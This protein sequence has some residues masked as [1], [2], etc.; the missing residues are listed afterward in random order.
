MPRTVSDRTVHSNKIEE[1]TRLWTTTTRTWQRIS[2]SKKLSSSL[3]LFAWSACVFSNGASAWIEPAGLKTPFAVPATNIE[4]LA[5]YISVGRNQIRIFPACCYT[6]LSPFQWFT[7]FCS[8]TPWN[9]LTY[10]TLW[11]TIEGL[12]F[13]NHGKCLQILIHE[14]LSFECILRWTG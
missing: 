9:G 13:D 5:N 3:F 4:Q 12:N 1:S 10:R 2:M 8:C 11:V 7:I 14:I 6:K